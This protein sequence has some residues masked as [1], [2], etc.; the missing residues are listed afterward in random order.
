MRQENFLAGD[1]LQFITKSVDDNV[2]TSIMPKNVEFPAR[3]IHSK[4]IIQKNDR[5][6][7]ELYAT[8]EIILKAMIF[9]HTLEDVCDWKL[10]GNLNNE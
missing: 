6:I 10:T 5:N 7:Y 3:V 2:D 8:P 1:D 4:V 9:Y